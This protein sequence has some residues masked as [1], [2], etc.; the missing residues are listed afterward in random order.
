MNL[1]TIGSVRGS[2]GVTTTAQL[3]AGVLEDALL[4]EADLA[5]GVLAIRYGL[6]REPGLTTLAAARTSEPDAWR[7]HAQSAGG[8]PVLVGPDS[9]DTSESLWRSVGPRLSRTL[10]S[11]DAPTVVADVGRLGATSPLVSES[12]LVLLLVRPIAEHLVALSHRV[13]HLREP[14]GPGRV[15]VILVGDGPYR[16]NDVAGPLDVEVAGQLPDDQRAASMLVVGG[17][18]RTGFARTRLARAAAGLGVE[19]GRF[20]EGPAIVE[21]AQR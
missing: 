2:P 19:I 12:D 5:G 6:G 10:R 16:P 20:L 9:P 18:P 4:V 13:A 7:A 17:R 1:V 11:C 3:L 21:G 14:T 8:V 15:A